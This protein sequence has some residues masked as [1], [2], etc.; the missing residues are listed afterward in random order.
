MKKIFTGILVGMLA[1]ATYSKAQAPEAGTFVIRPMVGMTLSTFGVDY[2]SEPP[3]DFS[4]EEYES[5]FKAGFVIGAEAGYQLN[6]WL[7]PSVGLFFENMGTKVDVIAPAP[8]GTTALRSD[9]LVMPILANFYVYKGLALK[10]GIQPGLLL[11]AR[12]GGVDVTDYL[13]PFQLHVPVGISYEY[14][15]FVLDARTQIPVLKAYKKKFQQKSLQVDA[16]HNVISI[17]LGY[18]FEL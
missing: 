9:F 7:Q 17:T 3:Y 8:A 10:A 12:G 5:K 1:F 16:L 6:K 18:N 15:H 4:H 13:K 14:R 2:S 11:N